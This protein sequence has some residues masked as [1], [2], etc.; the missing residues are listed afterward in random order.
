MLDAVSLAGVR[1]LSQGLQFLLFLFAARILS[2]AEFGVFSV[3]FAAIVGV[4]VLAEAGWREY[5]ICCDDPEAPHQLNAVSFVSGALL[6]GVLLLGI[7]A[8]SALGLSNDFARIGRLLAFW[9]WLRPL[10]M[11]QVGLLTRT[12]KLRALAI[13]Q[14]V[15]EIFGFL[16][17]AAALWLGYGVLSLAIGKVALVLAELAGSMVCARN[18]RFSWPGNSVLRHIASFSQGILGARIL[19]FAQGNYS[20]LAVG[21]F[22]PPALVGIYRA[23]I[24]LV[25]TA[26]E[27]VRE[28]AKYIGW[29]SLRRARDDAAEGQDLLPEAT[30]RFVQLV[31]LAAAPAL[32]LMSLT[33]EPLIELL[34][35]PKWLGAAPLVAIL[36]LAAA[37]RLVAV[38]VEPVMALR[39]STRHVQQNA[40]V[41]FT[42][43]LVCFTVAVPFGLIAIAW[44]ELAAA[45][46][47]VPI[48]LWLMHRHGGIPSAALLK[49]LMPTV[50]AC[51]V[52]WGMV[53]IIDGDGTLLRWSPLLHITLIG[54]AV[55]FIQAT[56]LAL[57]HRFAPR[58]ALN[59]VN[60][61]IL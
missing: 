27:V 3:V 35:G 22:F 31:G 53:R 59:S 36:A 40:M 33:A 34:I 7:A 11:V 54:G 20:T 39:G 48:S 10:A 12:A 43:N 9:V 14:L 49:A 55:L 1:V 24:R 42:I 60:E 61:A 13:V 41:L 37:L 28:P 44:A 46:V 6:A 18:F 51:A 32:V 5:A 15:S 2:T 23:A 50:V 25:G 19:Q 17:G 45:A 29:S 8:G 57:F 38:A 52:C 30:V 56:V 16:L 26:Q 58:D 4:T 21:V 47:S